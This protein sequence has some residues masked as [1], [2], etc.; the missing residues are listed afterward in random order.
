MELLIL[1]A[2]LVY[3]LGLIILFKAL[4]IVWHMFCFIEV[5]DE[6]FWPE[7]ADS[8]FLAVIK[9]TSYD[10]LKLKTLF[11]KQTQWR[12]IPYRFEDS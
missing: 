10:K 3:S 8:H 12:D 2:K 5:N 11:H 9:Q 6:C 4:E 7:T 1:F